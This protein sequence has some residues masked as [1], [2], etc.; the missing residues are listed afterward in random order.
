MGTVS[1]AMKTLLI[2]LLAMQCVLGVATVCH[3][4]HWQSIS[5]QRVHTMVKEGSG[6]WLVDVRNP[7]AFEQ[8]HIESAVNIPSEQLKVKNLP[9]GKA[10]VLVDDSLGLRHARSGAEILLK[11]GYEKIFIMDGGIPAWESEKLSMTATRGD[12]L[13]SVMWDDL[14]WAT[15][16]S[17]AFKMYDLRDDAEKT[18]GPMEGAIQLKGNNPDERLKALVAQLISG[19][20]KKGLAGKL[21]K[22]VPI[23]LVLPN[24][25]KII[26][27]VRSALK[28]VPADVRYLEGAYAL[29][30]A[31]EKEKP[32]PGPEVC[33]TCPAGRKK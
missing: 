8:G 25:T 28:G 29:W 19:E 15:S 5:P 22:P 10:I 32:L 27:S 33:P 23:V 12:S 13:R 11:K 3:S 7:A 2:L 14:T 26:D 21:E 6:L 16:A 18:R 31:R 4:S 17:V 30:V 9:K 24:N 1:R 20:R